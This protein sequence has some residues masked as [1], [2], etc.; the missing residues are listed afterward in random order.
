MII[1]LWIVFIFSILLILAFIRMFFEIGK[2]T[3]ELKTLTNELNLFGRFL[4]KISA[5]VCLIIDVLHC[6]IKRL[7][8]S[9]FYKKI[10]NNDW[11]DEFNI[12]NMQ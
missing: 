9:L 11:D 4:Y 8:K 7:F 5:Y 1:L 12:R 3:K 6:I 2:S 10:D